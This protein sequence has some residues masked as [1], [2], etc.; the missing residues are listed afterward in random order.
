MPIRNNV[1]IDSYDSNAQQND[2]NPIKMNSRNLQHPI[3]QIQTCVQTNHFEFS[4]KNE[5]WF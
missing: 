4:H 3:Q 5:N 1:V 2:F